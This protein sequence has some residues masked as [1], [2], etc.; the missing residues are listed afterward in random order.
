MIQLAD[1]PQVV[2]V[3]DQGTAIEMRE[4]KRKIIERMASTTCKVEIPM[5]PNL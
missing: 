5:F 4:R 2:D 3:K 1:K